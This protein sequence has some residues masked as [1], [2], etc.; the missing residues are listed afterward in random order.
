MGYKFLFK[1]IFILSNCHVMSSFCNS[2]CC[3]M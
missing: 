2:N 1:T 3:Q